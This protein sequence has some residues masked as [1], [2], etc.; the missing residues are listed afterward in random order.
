MLVLW[1]VLCAHLVAAFCFENG[2]PADPSNRLIVYQETNAGGGI[3]SRFSVEM[4]PGE[5]QCCNY[6]NTDCNRAGG[7]EA[8]GV[9]RCQ[10]HDV[11]TNVV[12][13]SGGYCLHYGDPNHPTIEVYTATGQPFENFIL[14]RPH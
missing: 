2:F 11:V 8:T 12:V 10:I 9:F 6:A 5:K 7:A 3:A 13:P 1:G 14:S 4:G